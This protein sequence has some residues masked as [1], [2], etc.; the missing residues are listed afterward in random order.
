[1]F[2]VR[3][4]LRRATT[5]IQ[6][7]Q[8]ILEKPSSEII[9]ARRTHLL[10]V[11]NLKRKVWLKPIRV[12]RRLSER[13]RAQGTKYREKKGEGRKL[14]TVQLRKI[15][16]GDGG[17]ILRHQ[18]FLTSRRFKMQRCRDAEFKVLA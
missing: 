14:C 8:R 17:L 7:L 18:K 1:M 6:L 13:P 10:V 4:A 11:G 12:L 3:S 9:G 15:S 16:R 5:F 2:V